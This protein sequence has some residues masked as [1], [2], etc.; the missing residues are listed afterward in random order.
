MDWSS[1]TWDHQPS[2]RQDPPTPRLL[3]TCWRV[4]GP[5]RQPITVASTST[6][7]L[8]SSHSF[9]SKVIT[10]RPSNTIMPGKSNSHVGDRARSYVVGGAGTAMT[11][12]NSDNIA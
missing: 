6:R 5:S 2:K 1:R 8:A 11:P 9:P 10:L 3:E 4:V 7:G 12:P